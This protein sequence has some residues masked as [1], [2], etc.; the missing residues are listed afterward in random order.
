VIANVV[1]AGQALP[2]PHRADPAI[3]AADGALRAADHPRITVEGWTLRWDRDVWTVG[4]WRVGTKR[5]RWREATWHG[6]IDQALRR[7]L[8]RCV[9]GEVSELKEVLDR[10]EAAYATIGEAVAAASHDAARS[11]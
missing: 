11:D 9:E 3:Q 2:V 6:R 4:Q 5:T 8:D 7:F 1:R 10:V